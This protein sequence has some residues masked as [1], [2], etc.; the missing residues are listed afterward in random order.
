MK[1]LITGASSGIGLEAAKDLAKRG[2]DII[3]V[4]RKAREFD[5]LKKDFPNVNFT[6]IP[7]DLTILDENKK[8]V[9]LMKDEDIDFYFLNAGKGV[10]GS[11]KDSNVDEEMKMVQLNDLSNHYL[12]H[13]FLKKMQEENKGHM[14][15]TASA[16][17][18][19]P[20]PYMSAYYAS[21]VYI[22][23][24]CLGYY[25]ELKD[26]KSKATISILCP[27]PVDTNFEKAATVKF[28]IKPI[29]PDKVA[30][31]GVKKALKGKTVIVPGFMM[32]TMRILSKLAPK[33]FITIVDRKFQKKTE[34]VN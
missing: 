7:M 4:S 25:R 10:I 19:G 18:F 12:I 5:N 9:E 21:K 17:A 24:L 33:K 26:M 6:F 29:R 15:V 3:G 28:K 23:H 14:L 30:K 2:Y 8:L 1:A 13:E 31:L 16:A 27:G 34:K 22:Y 11:F 20:A 32:K